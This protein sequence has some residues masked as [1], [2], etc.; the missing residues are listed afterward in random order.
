VFETNSIETVWPGVMP[1]LHE[2]RMVRDVE[3]YEE[4]VRDVYKED[5]VE[6][7]RARNGVVVVYFT[8]LCGVR[9]TFEDGR[10]V[11]AILG[12]YGVRVDERDVSMHAA[13]KDELRGLL[14]GGLSLPRVF[15]V[16]DGGQHQQWQWHDLGGADDVRAQHARVLE[17]CE[18]LG[19]NHAPCLGCGGMRF[20]PCYTCYGRCSRV[21][22]GDGGG[23]LA[24][25]FEDCN[26]NELIRC[27]FCCCLCCIE[28]YY[29]LNHAS[30]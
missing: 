9:K 19:P 28:L 24:G 8:S 30:G 15:V 21:Y 3:A 18:P 17:D 22:A 13:F 1:E 26:E 2:Q 7:P 11:H 29:N 16:G 23:Y 14:D 4:E 12:A 10:A 25:T 27:P 6:A 20:Q 5:V